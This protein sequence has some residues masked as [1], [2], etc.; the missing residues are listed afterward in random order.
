MPTMSPD[1]VTSPAALA[2]ASTREAAGVAGRRAARPAAAGRRSRGCGSARRGGRR[3]SRRARPASPLQSGMSTSTATRR[4]ASGGSR[5]SSPRSRPRRRRRG[6]RGRRAVTTACARPM[7]STASATRA[8][9]SGSS[10]SGWRVSTRQKPHAR[11]QRSPWIMNVAVPSAQHSKMFGQPASS[12]TVTRS[13]SRIVC[14]QRAGT[15]RPWS[16]LRPQ[17]LRLARRDLTAR[18]ST[19]AC[20]QP[21]DAAARARRRPSTS[22]EER[23]V[24]GA[25][26]PH[27]VLA[28]ASRR[29]PTARPR[30]PRSTTS[31]TSRI[32]D[33]DALGGER[34]DALVGDAARHDVVEHREVGVDVEREAVHRAP[35]RQRTPIAAILRGASRRVDPH[36]G[37][38]VEPAGA[39][40]AE[41]GQRVDEQLL[42]AT[43]VGDRVGHAVAATLARQREDRVADELARARGR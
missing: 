1:F 14:L 26:A 13:R 23:Q 32:D 6:R 31:T 35:A 34:R 24:V 43:H 41:V 40:Q 38:A 16:H 36:A 22:A 17:P 37:V 8:G 3:R 19:P 39:A 9:S 20:G 33:V 18:R 7:R 4:R 29:D 5:R 21:A 28:L 27:D 30:E 15:R 2:R 25:V 12:H 42:D 10:A 11:V